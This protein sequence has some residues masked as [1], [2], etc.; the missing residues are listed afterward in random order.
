VL[1]EI[2]KDY[3]NLFTMTDFYIRSMDLIS[4]ILSALNQK[5]EGIIMNSELIDILL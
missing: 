2:K 1:L 3:E 5:V 4:S